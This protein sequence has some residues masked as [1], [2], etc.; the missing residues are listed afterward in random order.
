MISFKQ[1]PWKEEYVKFNNKK[2]EGTKSKYEKDVFELLS[3]NVFGKTCEN[4]K[5]RT[6][7]TG[8]RQHKL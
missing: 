3:N 5:N 8:N 4:L 7:Q 6:E 1:K 2:R